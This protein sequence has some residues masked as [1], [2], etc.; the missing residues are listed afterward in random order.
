MLSY[1]KN[2]CKKQQQVFL[3]FLQII[4]ALNYG[5]FVNTHVV[6]FFVSLYTHKT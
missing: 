5:E 4:S 3:I 6:L 2:I 1:A